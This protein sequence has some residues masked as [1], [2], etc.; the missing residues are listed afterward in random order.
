MLPVTALSG[1][2][3][4]C[5]YNLIYIGVQTT[6]AMNIILQPLI[7]LSHSLSMYTET[8]IN[9][10]FII[11]AVRKLNKI[12]RSFPFLYACALCLLLIS[13]ECHYSKGKG[14]K[15]DHYILLSLYYLATEDSIS[16]LS[17]EIQKD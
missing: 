8:S 12:S 10:A 6:E 16:D 5:Q 11:S 15:R 7:S 3:Q 13:C 4:E 17:K 9:L 2:V 1:L 14:E